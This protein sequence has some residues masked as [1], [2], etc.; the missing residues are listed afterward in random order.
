MHTILCMLLLWQTCAPRCMPCL[1]G[2]PYFTSPLR[3]QTCA[4]LCMPRPMGLPYFTSSLLWQ[5]CMPLCM[6]RPI[7]LPYFTLSLLWQTRAL[8]CMPHQIGLPYFTLSLL[9]QT[10]VPLCMPHQVRLPYFTS[11]L[12]WLAFVRHSCVLAAD[13]RLFPF[14]RDV[15][16]AF[17]AALLAPALVITMIQ[18]F[19]TPF[20]LQRSVAE[21]DRMPKRFCNDDMVWIILRCKTQ[22]WKFMGRGRLPG[23]RIVAC[24]ANKVTTCSSVYQSCQVVVNSMLRQQG[25]T[26]LIIYQ[27]CH[28]IVKQDDSH[29]TRLTLLRFYLRIWLSPSWIL[30][31]AANVFPALLPKK[32]AISGKMKMTVTF[33]STCYPC[34]HP[35]SIAQPYIP[36][37]EVFHI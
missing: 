32:W 28:A 29:Y 11:S 14:S 17:A 23:K 27:S 37:T 18:T 15:D 16:T 35:L 5:T 21:E 12:L 9:W 7:G 10:C 20:L 2:L 8:L 25:D 24:S 34:R 1:I 36:Y 30:P 6:P 22:T 31:I 33:S 26:T 4:S 13:L 3:W 19:K